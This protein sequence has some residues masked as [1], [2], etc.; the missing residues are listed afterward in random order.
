MSVPRNG[1]LVAAE[2]G[3]ERIASL[4]LGV[5]LSCRMGW[6]SAQHHMDGRIAA[7]LVEKLAKSRKP[8][9]NSAVII[10]HLI[11]RQ[12]SPEALVIQ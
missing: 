5:V 2:I 10:K 8:S 12:T 7:S 3:N 1:T 9:R 11:S 6:V 4:C